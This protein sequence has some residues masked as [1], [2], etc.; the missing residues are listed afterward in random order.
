MK[1]S[2]YT[3]EQKDF[4]IRRSLTGPAIRMIMYQGLDK[5]LL[6]ILETLDSV[7]GNIENKEQLLKDFYSASRRDDEDVS[8][9]SNRL[10]EIIGKGLES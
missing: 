7:Y 6:D 2:G 5:S 8:A 4:A 10:E 1:D 9:W 3:R